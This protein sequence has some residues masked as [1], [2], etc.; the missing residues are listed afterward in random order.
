MLG[1]EI[2]RAH[3][4]RAVDEIAGVPLEPCDFDHGVG[5]EQRAQLVP[6][7]QISV[8]PT[9]HQ[10]RDGQPVLQVCIHV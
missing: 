8:H 6:F 7:R 3:P 2:R 9:G 10:V 5:M 1:A 4:H